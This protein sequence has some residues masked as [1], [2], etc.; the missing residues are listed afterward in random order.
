ML[1][2][3]FAC[4]QV[5]WSL[6][7][8]AGWDIEKLKRHIEQFEV[9]CLTRIIDP[10]YWQQHPWN[11]LFDCIRNRLAYNGAR[12]RKR[13][14]G[15]WDM[16]RTAHQ[17]LATTNPTVPCMVWGRADHSLASERLPGYDDQWCMWWPMI[18][19]PWTICPGFLNCRWCLCVDNTITSSRPWPV[20]MSRIYIITDEFWIPATVPSPGPV[21]EEVTSDCCDSEGSEGVTSDFVHVAVPA[22]AY[23]WIW[24][25][26]GTSIASSEQL[27]IASS[28][29]CDSEGSFVH[30]ATPASS[31]SDHAANTAATLPAGWAQTGTSIASSEELN[32]A[33]TAVASSATLPDA[34]EIVE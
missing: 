13:T 11:G 15:Y 14:T 23:S 2:L 33:S 7:K 8:D 24:D 31:H 25:Q 1:L 32:I 4:T 3:Q 20:H 26:T 30:V 34:W 27:D 6:L 28:D 21:I 29:C 18:C 10:L 9:Q 22:S 12:T 17:P 16:M 5:R 19:N